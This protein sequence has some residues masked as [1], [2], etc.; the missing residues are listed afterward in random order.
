VRGSLVVALGDHTSTSIETGFYCCV[1][2]H[3]FLA[4]RRSTEAPVRGSL[5]VALG[6]HTLT[7]IETCFYCCVLLHCFLAPRRSTEAPVRG[8]LVVA[9]GDLAFR[10]PN[11]LEPWTPHMYQP[12]GDPDLGAPQN[13]DILLMFC[14][15]LNPKD[16]E[17]ED[18]ENVCVNVGMYNVIVV[19]TGG[20]VPG[21]P[22]PRPWQRGRGW[23]QGGR[24]GRYAHPRP[25]AQR[26]PPRWPALSCSHDAGHVHKLGSFLHPQIQGAFPSARRVFRVIDARTCAG[27]RKTCLKV[28][29]HLILSDM[30]KVKG[31]IARI[32]MCMRESEEQ[33]TRGP[34]IRIPHHIPHRIPQLRPASSACASR[35][36]PCA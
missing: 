27:V 13:H 20:P 12:L 35:T 3:C 11:T 15:K 4:P 33:V 8:S 2:L 16:L 34:P 30:M 22:R 14:S 1:L 26:L 5:V 32:A 23:R 17:K 29:S 6:D 24:R 7:S 9:L 31:H 18:L 21:R 36:P 25:S 28:L 19:G 10:F